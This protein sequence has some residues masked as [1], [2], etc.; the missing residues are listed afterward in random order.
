MNVAAPICALV[1]DD[2]AIAQDMLIRLV[3]GLREAG[4]SI[5]GTIQY[6]RARPDRRHCDMMLENLSSGE[7]V[8]ISEDRGP[9]ASGC[10]LD[11][12]A[13][14]RVEAAVRDTIDSGPSI[15]II[16]KFG[17]TEIEGGGLRAVIADAI[18]KDI[19]TLVGVPSRN[20]VEWNKFVGEHACEARLEDELRRWLLDAGV[21]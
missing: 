6:D 21:L 14:A 7:N 8:R 16:N 5:A 19:P 17:K 9:L 15:L 18:V 11:R 12:D 10:R 2:G 3:Q 1:Y 20:I 13:F 4:K